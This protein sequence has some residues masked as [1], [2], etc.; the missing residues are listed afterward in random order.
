[1]RGILFSLLVSIT[2]VFS[3]AQELPQFTSDD[4][5]N[6]SYNNPGIELSTGNIGSGM[7]SLYVDSQGRALMLTSTPFSCQGIDSIA[8]SVRWYTKSIHN[9]NFD[10]AKTALTLAIDD[11]HGNPIDSVTCVPTTPGT[12]NHNLEL[13]LP[14]PQGLTT[15]RLR[16]VS[17][18]GNV[19]S[20]GAVKRALFTAITA[21][22]HDNIKGDVDGN[23][24]VSINDVTLLIDYLLTSNPSGIDL[25]AADVDAD[26]NVNISDVT[27]LID[28]L[29]QGVAP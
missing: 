6:W 9:A 16:L 4:Y 21:Q 20:S 7:I 11:A 8:A 15:A 23:H 24:E 14:V 28:M 19:I 5:Q 18:T 17:W 10:L 2:A 3:L 13:M 25:E 26:G 12:S 22:P 27:A 1:M 29:L